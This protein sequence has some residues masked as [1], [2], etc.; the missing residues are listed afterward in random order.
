MKTNVTWDFHVDD[1]DESRYNIISGVDLLMDCILDLK[2][3][4]QTISR[5][6]GPFEGFT[7]IVMGMITHEYK[8]KKWIILNQNNTL[9]MIM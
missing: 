7:E 5:Q 6:E 8:P 4:E 1:Y 2:F 9:W 3:S